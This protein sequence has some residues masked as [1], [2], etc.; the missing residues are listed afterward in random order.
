MIKTINKTNNLS[1]QL[2]FGSNLYQ[3]A[4]HL[5]VKGIPFLPSFGKY[6]ITICHEKKFVWFRVAKVGTR[7]IFDVLKISGIHLDAEHPMFCHYP[8]SMYNNYFKFAFVRNPYDRLVS[9]W[10]NKV[11]DS[12]A[13]GFS[14]EEL[15][16]MQ[17]FEHFVDFV[18]TQNIEKCNIHFRSQS[19]LIDLN[20]VNYIGRFENF[21]KDLSHVFKTM[22]IDFQQ[23]TK[24]NVSSKN[25]LNYR[26]YYNDSLRAKV[27]KIY[28]KDLNIFSYDF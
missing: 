11:V 2:T 1:G 21:E 26:D 5:L 25:K 6:N 20:S 17:N 16:E 13:F 22:N 4:S 27:A 28:E 3:K 23:I 8:K 14:D 18:A 7:T 19:K 9:C 10:R 24:K 15:L 12:N